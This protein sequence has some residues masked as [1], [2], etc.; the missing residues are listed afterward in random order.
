MRSSCSR[1]VRCSSARSA[2]HQVGRN[3]GPAAGRAQYKF[4]AV[5]G[6]PLVLL[7]VGNTFIPVDGTAERPADEQRFGLDGA[8]LPAHSAANKHVTGVPIP[9]AFYE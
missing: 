8:P 1:G 9:G 5:P 2:R 3:G 4:E 7:R 6:E